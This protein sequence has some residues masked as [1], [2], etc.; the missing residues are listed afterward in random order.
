LAEETGSD[1]GSTAVWCSVAGFEA[2]GGNCEMLRI[3]RMNCGCYSVLLTGSVLP[4]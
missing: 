1:L 3:A 4:A 2:L